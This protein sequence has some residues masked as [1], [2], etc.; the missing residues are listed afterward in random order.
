MPAGLQLAASFFNNVDR[1]CVLQIKVHKFLKLALGTLQFYSCRTEGRTRFHPPF[2]HAARELLAEHGEEGRVHEVLLQRGQ[3]PRFQ[4]V[5][6][7]IEAVLTGSF[8]TSGGAADMRP[9]DHGITAAAAPT[10]G[11]PGE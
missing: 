8:V 4:G 1:Y 2:I 10:S 9:G 7:D 3:H 5:A 11:Q 6:A